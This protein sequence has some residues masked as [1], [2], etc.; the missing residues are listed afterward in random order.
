MRFF[1]MS[2]VHFWVVP[3]R[4]FSRWEPA[5]SS[6]HNILISALGLV[7]NSLPTAECF[8]W[9][10]KNKKKDGWD[11]VIRRSYKVDITRVNVLTVDIKKKGRKKEKN[12]YS[13]DFVLGVG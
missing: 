5:S 3:F 10:E 12:R 11:F 7:H 6:S 9:T 4:T 13:L 8:Y 1:R 2:D